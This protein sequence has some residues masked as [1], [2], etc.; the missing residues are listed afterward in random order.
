MVREAAFV[1]YQVFMWEEPNN[2]RHC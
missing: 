1:Y 2:V